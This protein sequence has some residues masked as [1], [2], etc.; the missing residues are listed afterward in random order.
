MTSIFLGCRQKVCDV[1]HLKINIHLR[2]IS[3]AN[4][5]FPDVMQPRPLGYITFG[6][7]L[8]GLFPELECQ[9]D[10]GEHGFNFL[11]KRVTGPKENVLEVC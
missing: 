3:F 8:F 1:L 4:A 10:F 2:G 9:N 11:I 6:T 5:K 7:R